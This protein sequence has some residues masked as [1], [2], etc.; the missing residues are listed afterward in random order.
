MEEVRLDQAYFGPVGVNR[1]KGDWMC[2]EEPRFIWGQ[3]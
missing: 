2:L 1:L 3:T